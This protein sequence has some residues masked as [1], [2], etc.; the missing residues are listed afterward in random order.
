MLKYAGA[1]LIFHDIMQNGDPNCLSAPT[2]DGG[3]CNKVQR[4]TPYTVHTTTHIY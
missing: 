2:A 4:V 3:I 1:L